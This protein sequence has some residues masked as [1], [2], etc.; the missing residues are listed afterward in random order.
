MKKKLFWKPKRTI[1]LASWSGEEYGLIG[2]TAWGEKHSKGVLKRAI[3]YLNVD[4]GVSG[5]TF[6]LVSSATLVRLIKQVLKAVPD[7]EHPQDSVIRRWDGK[8]Y[9]IGSGSDYAVFLHHLGIPSADMRFGANSGS[10]RAT[11]YGTYHS[12]FDSFSW[13]E[14]Y[15]D[16]DFSFHQKMA[17][18]WGVCA[19]RLADATTLPLFHL[20]QARIIQ[21][22]VERVERMVSDEKAFK[23][24]QKAAKEYLDV[25]KD[26]DLKRRN[27]RS[28]DVDSE[29]NNKL[30]FSERFFIAKEGLPRR[31][32][33]KH[34]LHAPGLYSG[35]SADYL[36]GIVQGKRDEK[37]QEL[38]NEQAYLFAARLQ[39]V[40]RFLKSGKTS[41]ESIYSSNHDKA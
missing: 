17:I 15:A 1:I 38:A 11:D 20:D 2:S 21:G 30:A 13:M 27:H 14:K 10:G 26:I 35:Y 19:L 33:F 32:W 25:S 28:E 5:K 24:M 18:I 37:N 12:I 7:P 40:S 4:I 6:E 39:A 36:P 22:E 3:A 8:F 9:P 23:E 34:V 29:L 41:V 31:K 16:P